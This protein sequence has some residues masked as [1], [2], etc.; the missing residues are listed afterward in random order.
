MI[1]KRYFPLH[2]LQ[3][4]DENRSSFYFI[5]PLLI[6]IWSL[7]GLLFII[8]H[9]PYLTIGLCIFGMK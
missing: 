4:F 5:I 9:L 6:I 3:Y 8:Y 1:S 7:L 2:Q